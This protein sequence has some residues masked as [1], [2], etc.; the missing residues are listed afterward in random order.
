[1]PQSTQSKNPIVCLGI[2]DEGMTMKKFL[3]LVLLVYAVLIAQVSAAFA[4]NAS[5]V[6]FYQQYRG[7]TAAEDKTHGPYTS[8]YWDKVIAERYDGLAVIQNPNGTYRY[9]SNRGCRLFTYAH[10]I[11]RLTGEKA[12][13]DRQ[14]EI[15]KDLL[16]VNPDPPNAN[17]DY[18]KYI[19]E[20]YASEHG[21]EQVSNSVSEDMSWTEVS[22]FFV[23]GGVIVFNSGGHIALAVDYLEKEIDGKKQE[24]ILLID[25]SARSTAKRLKSGICYNGSFSKT[26]NKSKDV[27]PSWNSYGR[28]WIK[29]S[30]FTAG[31]WQAA[32]TSRT[33]K[34]NTIISND[35]VTL[36]STLRIGISIKN[37]TGDTDDDQCYIKDTPYEA[38]A[39]L[40]VI[41]KGDTIDIVGA[42]KNKH[43]N[44]WYKTSDG[45]YVYSGDV[46]VYVYGD[47][48]NISATFKNT[49]KRESHV[50]PYLDSPDV[51]TIK[52]ND[53]VIVTK[54]VVNEKGNIWAKLSD[55]SY[56][57]FYDVDTKENK[58]TFVDSDIATSSVTKPT[59]DIPLKKS[60]GLRGTITADAPILS[61]TAQVTNRNTGEV[62][63]GPVTA[64]VSAYNSYV[65]SLTLNKTVN[66]TNIN[67]KMGFSKLSVAGYYRYEVIV[68][69][70][71]PYVYDGHTFIFGE[72]QVVISSDFTAGNPED[73]E[74]LP[75][76]P[77]DPTLTRLPGDANEDGEVDIYDALVILRYAAG[78]D[79][80]IC[81]YNADVNADDQADI[82]DAILILQQGAGWN[83]EL[84]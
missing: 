71:F 28:L 44:T 37:K 31:D 19:E 57:C 35:I 52:K 75:D 43:G 83:V 34:N 64:N 60:F 14:I 36:D 23:N 63:V 25:S 38:G 26:Y 2:A 21:V 41:A 22:A 8:G 10:A 33:A 47:L 48:F 29:Y 7:S 62:A 13:E 18:A 50:A 20:K 84:L 68:Q 40:D 78:Q 6:S 81:L 24:L 1:M 53:T 59:G 27:L 42:V 67:D 15:L 4:D 65:N 66:G 3:A 30:D 9:L 76:V 54:F 58:L 32:F 61:V 70:G 39:T 79:V 11:Q 73:E 77:D 74:L 45:N 55:G 12:T 17:G 56:L 49:E 80:T 82:L 16:K 51:N 5:N 72:E 46:T 69:L